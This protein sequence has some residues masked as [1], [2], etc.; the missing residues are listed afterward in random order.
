VPP[1]E[2]RR[3]SVGRTG[4]AGGAATGTNR[5]TLGQRAEALGGGDRCRSEEEMADARVGEVGEVEEVVTMGESATAMTTEMFA[6]T[7]TI[8]EPEFETG[9]P[10]ASNVYSDPAQLRQ[11]VRMGNGRAREVSRMD[12]GR[13]ISARTTE[14]ERRSWDESSAVCYSKMEERPGGGGQGE[15]VCDE[16]TD[17]LEQEPAR[18]RNRGRH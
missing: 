17:R 2:R 11:V 10:T 14:R 13:G 15:R 8:I 18:Q 1:E 5:I 12:G 9:A 6:I 3:E 4:R 7:A 16:R